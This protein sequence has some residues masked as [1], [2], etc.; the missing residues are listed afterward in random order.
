VPE[1]APGW[2]SRGPDAQ[3]KA[4]GQALI[5]HDR[6]RGAAPWLAALRGAAASLIDPSFLLDGAQRLRD[7]PTEEAAREACEAALAALPHA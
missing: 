1:P 6:S 4:D 5:F 2:L 3:E 7:F